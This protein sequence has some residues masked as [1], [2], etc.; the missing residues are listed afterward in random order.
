MIAGCKRLSEPLGGMLSR[1]ALTRVVTHT[2]EGR[3]SMA[4][5]NTSLI[6]GRS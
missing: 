3:E 2:S 6:S 4:H 5:P 1:P